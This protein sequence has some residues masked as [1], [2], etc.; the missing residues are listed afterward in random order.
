M[1]LSW[2]NNAPHATTSDGLPVEIWHMAYIEPLGQLAVE[3]RR[4]GRQAKFAG[5][6]RFAVWRILPLVLNQSSPDISRIDIQDAA[7]ILE[8]KNAVIVRLEEPLLSLAEASFA[9]A[10]LGKAV[11]QVAIDGVPQ[12]GRNQPPL[13]RLRGFSLVDM[14]VLVDA[15]NVRLAKQSGL[16]LG[17]TVIAVVA[18]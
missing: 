5:A 7:N 13:R 17:E 2:K 16:L 14:E 4:L 12:N 6:S 3:R 10:I 11:A 15:Q 1:R 9:M 18:V 8:A